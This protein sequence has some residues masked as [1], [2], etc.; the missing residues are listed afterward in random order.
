MK[1]VMIF[2][3]TLDR[4]RLKLNQLHEAVENCEGEVIIKRTRDTLKTN[5][6]EFVAVA[7]NHQSIG[8][9]ASFLYIDEE[10][11]ENLLQ[12]VVYPCL[13][14]MGNDELPVEKRIRFFSL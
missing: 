7:A 12:E 4:A 14:H 8:Y 13:S 11:P 9:R 10:I 5:L 6:R 3:N 1:R 2:G